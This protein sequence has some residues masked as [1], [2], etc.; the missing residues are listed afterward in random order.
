M[1]LKKI[2]DI[3]ACGTKSR[4]LFFIALALYLTGIP[5]SHFMMSL[6]GVILVLQWLF[7]RNLL[8]KLKSF[9]H[10]KVALCCLLVYAVHVVWL[11]SSVNMT[12]ALSDLWIKIPLLFIPLIFFTSKPLSEKEFQVLLQIYVAGVLIASL[13]GF[14]AYQ[15]GTLEDKRDMALFISYIRFGINI[16][17][18]V[19]VAFSLLIRGRLSLWQKTVLVVVLCWFLF[20]LIYSGSVTAIALFF[21]AGIIGT[22]RLVMSSKNKFFRRIILCSFVVLITGLSTYLYYIVRQYFK[23]DFSIETAAKY[24]ADGNPYSHNMEKQH[25]ENGSYIYTYVSEKELE[26]AWNKRSDIKYNDTDENGFPIRTTL[27]RYLNSKKLTKDRIGVE[28]LTDEDIS[29]VRQ[30]IANVV[31]TYRLNIAGRIYSLMW[32]LNDY[33][34]TGSVVGYSFP[35][36]LELWKCSLGSIGKH[37]WFG[38]GT[39]DGKDVFAQELREQK[40][41]LANKGMRSHNQYLTFLILFGV[42]GLTLI[43]FSILY[44]VVALRKTKDTLFWIFF[45]IMLLSMLTEDTLEPQD[46][47][48]FFA[49]FYSFFLFLAPKKKSEQV[50]E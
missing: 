31:Y 32:E 43:L 16:C 7:D 44:P 6:A 14:I 8:E 15:T 34:C 45:S 11:I 48:T 13:L 46:G 36:R 50:D 18:A 42:V 24:T 2:A 27:I 38:V 35:Q 40:S 49:F 47:V 12:Y 37:P 3:A 9:F 33:C 30:G 4:I 39:G 29:N 17:F 22:V 10:S 5:F 1:Q 28:A 20:F 23:V 21:A 25:I 26:E 19:F 41:P